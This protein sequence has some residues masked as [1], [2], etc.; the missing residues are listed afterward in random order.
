MLFEPKGQLILTY[1]QGLGLETN[2]VAEE[3]ALWQGL[4]VAKERGIQ[5]LIIIGDSQISQ[6]T[7]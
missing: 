4:K 1:A 5:D 2:N 3:T 6:A 7:W